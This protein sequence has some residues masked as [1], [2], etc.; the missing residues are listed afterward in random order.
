M[1]TEGPTM[2]A[3]SHEFQLLNVTAAQARDQV[4]ELE[5]ERA[6]ALITDLASDDGYMH[7][8]EDELAVRRHHYVAAAV[9]EIATLLADLS[10]AN[11]G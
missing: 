7:D 5:S 9:T 6:L 3:S 8:L 2:A 4:A 11:S 10:G 1:S